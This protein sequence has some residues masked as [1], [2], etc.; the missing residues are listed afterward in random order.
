[1]RSTRCH[2]HRPEDEIL[3]KS[4]RMNGLKRQAPFK[5]QLLQISLL[6]VLNDGSVRRLA[7]IKT[8][9]FRSL[10]HKGMKIHFKNI[11]ECRAV[12][13]EKRN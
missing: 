13:K 7:I 8:V 1:M 11:L 9:S 4:S 6:T 5:R 12:G 3:T 10:S 2:S